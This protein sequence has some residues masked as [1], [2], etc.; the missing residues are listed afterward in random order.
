MIRLR[1]DASL[2]VESIRIADDLDIGAELM[3]IRANRSPDRRPGHT[4]P[5]TPPRG[6]SA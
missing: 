5:R 4:G 6:E 2:I 3:G 1:I